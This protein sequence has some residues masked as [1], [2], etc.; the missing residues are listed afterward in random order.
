M[1]TYRFAILDIHGLHM[2]SVDADTRSAGLAF[3]HTRYP[4]AQVAGY[5]PGPRVDA[6]HS[7]LTTVRNWFA[8]QQRRQDQRSAFHTGQNTRSCPLSPTDDL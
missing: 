8:I 2:G 6:F 1:T 4:E 3:L 7:T 5:A